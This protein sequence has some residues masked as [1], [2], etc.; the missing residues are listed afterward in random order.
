MPAFPPDP[1]NPWVAHPRLAPHAIPERADHVRVRVHAGG[2]RVSQVAARLAEVRVTGGDGYAFFGVLAEPVPGLEPLARGSTIRFVAP[3]DGS[4][5]LL[6][7]DRYLAERPRWTIHPCEHCGL[8]ELYDAPS[9][10]IKAT[11][12]ELGAAETPRLFA[13]A[14]GAC[15]GSQLVQHDSFVASDE[16]STRG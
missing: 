11:F 4:A 5:P 16:A 12:P 10:L 13:T 7:T 3:E 8:G 1:S 9:D 14:C 2:P 15:G 6:V